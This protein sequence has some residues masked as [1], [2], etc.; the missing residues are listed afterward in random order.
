M[1]NYCPC[2]QEHPIIIHD[3]NLNV[4]PLPTTFLFSPLKNFLLQKKLQN[5]FSEVSLVQILF[6]T[7]KM[8][9]KCVMKFL[10]R[11][12]R[13]GENFSKLNWRNFIVLFFGKFVFFWEI[14][15]DQLLLSVIKIKSL[16]LVKNKLVL[17]ITRIWIFFFWEKNL[18]LNSNS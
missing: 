1:K 18:N 17:N 5:V 3:T 11:G 9:R 15:T 6:L 8:F 16:T 4:N 2:Y 14:F 12:G 7:V 13:G 10:W